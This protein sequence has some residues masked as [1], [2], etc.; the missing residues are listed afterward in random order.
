MEIRVEHALGRDG[1]V[2]ALKAAAEAEGLS[3]P[4]SA[5][6]YGGSLEKETPL[7]AIRASWEVGETEVVVRIEK[8]PA[9]LPEATVVRFLEEGL[10]SAL[11]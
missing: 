5:D 9:F 10:R 8:K 7:G 1:A 3:A 11:Q 2:Q 4:E 6:P